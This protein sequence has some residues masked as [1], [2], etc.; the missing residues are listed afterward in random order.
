MVDIVDATTR[1]R[2]MSGIRSK[3]TQPE[4]AVRRALHARGFRFVLHASGLPGC[5][6]I[7]LPKWRV[8]IFVHGCFWHSHGCRLSK[9]PSSNTAFWSAKLEDNERRDALAHMTLIS[10]GWRTAVVWE[11]ALKTAQS[12]EQWPDLILQLDHWIRFQPSSISFETGGDSATPL[13]SDCNS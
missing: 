2:M 7:V 11:C 13:I 10:A 5:P 3:S 6:D 1:S 9:M 12:R 4:L 8:A